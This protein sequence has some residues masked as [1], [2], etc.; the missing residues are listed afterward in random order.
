[1]PSWVYQRPE[2]RRDMGDDTAPWYVGWMDAT[3]RRRSKSCGAGPD[4]LAAAR[5]LCQEINQDRLLHTFAV[6]SGRRRG[7]AGLSAE[8][9]AALA[10]QM[11]IYFIEAIGLERIKI[12]VTNNL[13]HR[14]GILQACSPIRLKVLL[15]MPGTTQTEAGFH[16]RFAA[17]RLHGEWFQ[18]TARL[19]DAIRALQSMRTAAAKP[20]PEN[21]S[22]TPP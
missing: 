7:M 20:P 2:Q 17:F 8:A 22:L 15:A 14:L 5:Q 21:G 11:V 12:G 16:R 10:G 19:R 13:S 9:I 4:G 3:G 6:F 1:M 18:A